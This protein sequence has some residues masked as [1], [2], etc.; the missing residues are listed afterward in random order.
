MNTTISEVLSFVTENDVKFIRLSFCS[1]FGV[2][3]NISILAEQ[4][5]SAFINGVS[6]D[7]TSVEGFEGFVGSDLLLFPDPST[8]TMLPWR[9]DPGSV[10]R[11]YCDIKTPQGDPFILD[12]RYILKRV[13][14][15]C[16]DMGYTCSIGTEC[17]FY[18]FLT[19][20]NGSPCYDTL[21]YGGFFD[22]APLDK[23]ENIR[24]DICLNLETMGL[25]PKTSYHEK[26][27]GQNEIDFRS[28]DAQNSAD[29]FLTFK[30][31]VR[32]I[33]ARSGLYASFM[34]KPLPHSNGSGLHINLSLSKGG[35]N[36][37]D[38]SSGEMRA[39]AGSF[40]AGV[41][42]KAPEMTMFLNPTINSYE[43]LGKFSVP[44][45]C[46]WSHDNRPQLIRIPQTSPE[47]AR[48]EL[49]SPDPTTNPYTAFALVIAAGL[50]GI[51]NGLSLPAA[52][53]G[54][55]D[56]KTTDNLR[57]LPAD[58]QQA[59]NLA[60]KSDFIR[61]VLGEEFVSRYIGAKNEEL[62]LFESC[63]NTEEFY[64]WKYFKY[65]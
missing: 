62:R 2:Q 20:E 13:L 51:E 43:R 10:I 35:Q 21:D 12:S 56:T 59:I 14:Q 34:P 30:S 45:Y 38:S 5:K 31:V 29:N 40:V 44:R 3:K 24:R 55:L 15:R 48:M 27:P 32:A 8:L 64:T 46:S 33:A 16:S 47:N 39:V 19:D 26:G 25:H 57:T 50:D 37:F 9:P 22:I 63:E 7:A 52:V 36:I 41:L 4:L 23:G 6:F 18:L 11:F 65:L 58:L 53:G 1:P 49:R 17:E 54:D 28:S 42:E 61:G 60:D